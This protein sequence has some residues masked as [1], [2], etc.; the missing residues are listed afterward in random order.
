MYV[1]AWGKTIGIIIE[2]L[3]ILSRFSFYFLNKLQNKVLKIHAQIMISESLSKIGKSFSIFFV[4]YSLLALK[5]FINIFIPC[6]MSYV[7]Q[8]S[9]VIV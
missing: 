3:Y 8:S 5:I 7:V 6:P 1:Y 4:E 2:L 9:I